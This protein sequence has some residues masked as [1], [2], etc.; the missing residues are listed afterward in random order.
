MSESMGTIRDVMFVRLA[1]EILLGRRTTP[2]VMSAVSAV[3]ML[4]LAMHPTAIVSM[5]H[6]AT[7]T[8]DHAFQPVV[9]QVFL[10]LFRSP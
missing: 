1:P 7:W 3:S 2:A 4:A 8:R 6:A 10:R 5:W 9:H